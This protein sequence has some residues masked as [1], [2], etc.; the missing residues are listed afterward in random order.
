MARSVYNIDFYAFII[1]GYILR[2]YGYTA[3]PFKVVVVE[4][5]FPELFL[6]PDQLC[7]IN[8]PVNQGRLAVI[9]VGDDG[10]VPNVL[11]T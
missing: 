3:L 7:L 2:E 6:V 8:H 9:D 4:N 11:H 1:Y 5:Q 10:D